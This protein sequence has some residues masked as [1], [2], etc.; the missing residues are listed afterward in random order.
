M[1]SWVWV[2]GR[3]G[4]SGTVARPRR[5]LTGFLDFAKQ[6]HSSEKKLIL[7]NPRGTLNAFGKPISTGL[8]SPKL[9]CVE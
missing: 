2:A 7:S 9:L 3:R 8:A 1:Q 6:F 4:S 5:S